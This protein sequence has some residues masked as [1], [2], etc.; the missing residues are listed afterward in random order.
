[1]AV[2]TTDT[3]INPKDGWTLLATA[4]TAPIRIKPHSTNRAWFLAIAGSLPPSTLSGLP[5]G[6]GSASGQD[7]E[8][9]SSAN[10]AENIYVR[11]PSSSGADA[12]AADAGIVFSMFKG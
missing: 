2:A 12:E 1:M 8:F 9:I 7:D 11:V 6:R 3:L 4:P 10:I 5:F